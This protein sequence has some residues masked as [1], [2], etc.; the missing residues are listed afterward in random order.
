MDAVVRPAGTILHPF[1]ITVAL[2][3]GLPQAHRSVRAAPKNMSEP[4]ASADAL[5]CRTESCSKDLMRALA[6][7]GYR[8]HLAATALLLWHSCGREA[9]RRREALS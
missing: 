2:F 7:L 1:P 4:A 6:E 8:G 5:R 9:A 3:G